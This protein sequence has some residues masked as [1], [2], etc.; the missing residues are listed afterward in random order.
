MGE[1]HSLAVNPVVTRVL[2]I[3]SHHP[4][5]IMKDNRQAGN[6]AA[7]DSTFVVKAFSASHEG[8]LMPPLW[9]GMTYNNCT[10]PLQFEKFH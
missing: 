3:P 10:F 2:E 8:C 9:A 7:F 1:K 4:L 5:F 6:G